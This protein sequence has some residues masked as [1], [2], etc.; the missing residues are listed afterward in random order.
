MKLS[1]I[2]KR[3]IEDVDPTAMATAN[4]LLFVD[5]LKSNAELMSALSQLQMPSDKYKAIMKFAGLIGIPE[6]RFED[7]MRN[8][9]AQ[10][11]QNT[12]TEEV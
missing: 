8:T 4:A 6:D 3:L 2:L 7:F 10:S 1:P 11:Q 5:Q 12:P 9:K